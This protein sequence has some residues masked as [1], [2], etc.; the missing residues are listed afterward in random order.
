MTRRTV[1]ILGANGRF[2][3]AAVKA[4]ADAGWRVLAQA[5]RPQA[6]LPPG[7]EALTLALGET[8]ALAAAAAGA[9]VVVHA[10]NPPY[11]DW[12]TQLMPLGRQGMDVAER[13]GALFMLPGNVY[14][15]GEAMPALLAEDTPERP[16]NAK[17]RLRAALEAEMRARAK[18]GRLRAVVLR[19]GDFYGCGEGSWL[20]LSIAKDLAKGRLVYP[21]PL[22]LPH[23]WAYLPDLAQAFVAVAERSARDGAPAFETLHFAGHTLTGGQFLD[24]LEAA[25]T[26]IGAAPAGRF[27]RGGMPWALIRLM[28]LFV[29]TLKAVAEMSYLWRVPHA[30]DG[31]RLAT[32]VAGLPTTPP[33]QALAQALRDLGFGDLASAH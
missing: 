31:A 10:V 27:R 25:A 15:Y 2:G 11:T 5:R 29:P 18:A 13:L 16:T 28:G 8:E 17:G 21:G 30:L 22:N 33:R 4:F 9:E 19:A 32:R 24:L 20:D 6:A 23:A 26:D 1:L 14:A 3:A 7:A 12:E